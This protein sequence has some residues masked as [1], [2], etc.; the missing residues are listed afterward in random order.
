MG[1]SLL[2]VKERSLPM[3]EFWQA[4]TDPDVTFLRTAILMGLLASAAFG[5]TGSLVVA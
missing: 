3:L 4:L 1:M 2:T 5:M